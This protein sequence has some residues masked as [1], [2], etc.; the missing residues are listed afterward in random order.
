[1]GGSRLISA[2]V[3][4]SAHAI[5]MPMC[6]SLNKKIMYKNLLNF[7]NPVFISLLILSIFLIISPQSSRELDLDELGTYAIINGNFFDLFH[8]YRVQGQSPLYY[9]VL[10]PLGAIF[11]FAPWV[12]RAPSII[13]TLIAAY[14]AFKLGQALFNKKAGIYAAYCFIC[15]ATMISFGL[16]AR[17]YALAM[18]LSIASS[19]FLIAWCQT[20][21]QK[22]LFT[23]I[24]LMVATVYTHYLW[25][26]V[27]LVHLI[28][29]AII[30]YRDE[31]SHRTQLL[32]QGL[33]GS[34]F[35][36]MISI[37]AFFDY[38]FLHTK[39]KEFA[40]ANP[41]SSQLFLETLFPLEFIYLI[42]VALI[43]RKQFSVSHSISGLNVALVDKFLLIILLWVLP[44]SINYLISATSGSSIFL[45]RYYAFQ[46]IGFFLLGGFIL[47]SLPYPR[48]S[49]FIIFCLLIFSGYREY[50]FGQDLQRSDR[51]GEI[52]ATI[53]N[54][55]QDKEC[56]VL[57]FSGFIGAQSIKENADQTTK[58]FLE[59][60]IKYHGLTNPITIIPYTFDTK[61]AL[62]YY[63][64]TVLP[65]SQTMTCLWL[66]ARK[67]EFILSKKPVQPSRLFL[68][69]EL[70]SM[71]YLITAESD[72]GATELIKFEK[73][74]F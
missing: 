46:L 38:I 64:S 33:H 24:T 12:L 7:Q 63:E 15:S 74:K 1:M 47:S 67:S 37:P 72:F 4:T 3:I 61:E 58:N 17:P 42:A 39:Q 49:K 27:F 23:Y 45:T 68:R 34:I 43:F 2:T 56:P 16:S 41:P 50:L 21:T 28:W 73:Q 18:M 40:F 29:F 14:F 13:F 60:P 35:M 55:K 54:D 19:Q 25:A 26:S 36:L 59:S 52:V 11:D 44:P 30:Y 32:Q 66:L 65:N 62:R 8:N 31:P 6:A 10:W 22:L 20:R 9:I 48:T 71:N 70:A 57:F 51:W 69:K 5:L 53:S